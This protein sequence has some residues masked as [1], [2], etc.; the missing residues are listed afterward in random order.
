MTTVSAFTQG[1]LV[2]SFSLSATTV[3]PAPTIQ[4][5]SP[6]VVK[7]GNLTG[8]MI[9]EIDVY[10]LS[11]SYILD[12]PGSIA[13]RMGVLDPKCTQEILACGERALYVYRYDTLVWGGYLWTAAPNLQ[14]VQFGGEGW[15]SMLGHRE[16]DWTITYTSDQ[17]E[18]AWD[19]IAH[20]QSE[21][22]GNLGI[23]R[24]S[25][26]LSGQ[27]I[28]QSYNSWERKKILDALTELAGQSPGFD[29]EITP[30][31]RWLTY[32]P[33]KGVTQE[34]A[35]TFLVGK[36]VGGLAAQFDA[37]AVVS[38]MTAIGSGFD[39][40]T[41]LSVASD[42]NALATFG[43]RQ[44]SNVYADVTKQA[45]LDAH[46]AADLSLGKI[47]RVNPNFQQLGDDPSWGGVAVGDYFHLISDWGYLTIDDFYRIQAIT[48]AVSQEGRENIGLYVG[49]TS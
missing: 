20:T 49:Q 37:T 6:Y 11:F 40:D 45:T 29:F 8:T 38:Q 30:D 36:N 16:I 24:G 14:E 13:F 5:D 4:N 1:G 10:D 17:F 9:A 42:D 27:S 43:L 25:L 31:K 7:V 21:D 28:A 41:L 3:L 12:S 48:V 22:F 39:K 26:D 35:Q 15:L 47:L 2:A 33:Q 32:Y 46:A 23:L 44:D 18:V 19:I 34:N